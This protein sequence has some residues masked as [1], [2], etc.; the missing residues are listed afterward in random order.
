MVDVRFVKRIFL[1]EVYEPLERLHRDFG[2]W[3]EL[4][5][6]FRFA[7]RRF[8]GFN[9][10]NFPSEVDLHRVDQFEGV[11]AFQVESVLKHDLVELLID[12]RHLCFEVCLQIL[13]PGAVL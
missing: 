9:P 10:G 4:R 11:R 13:D 3:L 5:R 7:T 8:E 1:A 6:L 2:P 12:R